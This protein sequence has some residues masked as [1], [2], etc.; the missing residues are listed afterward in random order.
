MSKKAK[1]TDAATGRTPH[2]AIAA[3]VAIIKDALSKSPARMPKA[4]L[5]ALDRIEKLTAEA[6]E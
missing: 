2:A 5:E 4:A 6:G 3:E 1:A